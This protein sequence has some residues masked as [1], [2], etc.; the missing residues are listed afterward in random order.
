[1]LGVLQPASA[2]LGAALLPLK[3]ADTPPGAIVTSSAFVRSTQ[4]VTSLATLLGQTSAALPAASPNVMASGSSTWAYLANDN[5][6]PLPGSVPPYFVD[7][8]FSST[9]R[10]GG[11]DVH[12]GV[13]LLVTVYAFTYGSGAAGGNPSGWAQLAAFPLRENERRRF[14]W[15]DLA[16]AV[17]PAGAPDALAFV[18]VVLAGTTVPPADYTTALVAVTP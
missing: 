18:P 13:R 3:P 16:S 8:V 7:V 9:P 17:G 2:V 4:A 14:D 6:L 12:P 15:Y 10:P 11:N 1:L 5:V